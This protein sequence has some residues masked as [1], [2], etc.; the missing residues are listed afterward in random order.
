MLTNIKNPNAENHPPPSLSPLTPQP[1]T[2]LTLPQLER[3]LP[4]GNIPMCVRDIVVLA[5]DASPQTKYKIQ[6]IQ[7]NT[8]KQNPAK[9]DIKPLN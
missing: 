9:M 4:W 3:T 5:S 2:K 7:P 8:N 1:R 6:Q